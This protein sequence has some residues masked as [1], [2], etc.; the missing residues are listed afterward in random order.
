MLH[1]L[2]ALSL[3]VTRLERPTDF[4]VIF[5]KGNFSSVLRIACTGDPFVQ[6]QAL[7]LISELGIGQENDLKQRVLK[8]GA[9][10][11]IVQVKAIIVEVKPFLIISIKS[12]LLFA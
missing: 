5:Q 12:F 4:D 7:H 9:V 10:P 2:R 6:L 1:V 3:I 8:S 11:A